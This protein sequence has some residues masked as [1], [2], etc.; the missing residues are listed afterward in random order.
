M[1]LEVF[2]ARGGAPEKG[3]W[4]TWMSRWGDTPL[5]PPPRSKAINPAEGVTPKTPTMKNPSHWDGK[6]VIFLILKL[7]S[8][9]TPLKSPPTV[10]MVGDR[11]LHGEVAY[12]E[13]AFPM[14]VEVINVRVREVNE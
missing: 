7:I 4:A 1:V 11:E 3:V 12:D 5:F 13:Y 9:V 2:D 8:K 10:L 14:Q 6:G